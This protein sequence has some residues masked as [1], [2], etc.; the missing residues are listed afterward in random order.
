MLE[1]RI[2][3]H[4]LVVKFTRRD[5]GG[6]RATCDEVPGFYLSSIDK[7]AV[8][9]DVVPALELLFKVN[10]GI[11]VEASPL[12]HAVYQLKERPEGV[13]EEVPDAD[14]YTREYVLEAA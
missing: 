5:D 8:M 7:R 13:V 12:G 4:K 11:A 14:E 9:G 3:K 1:H 2:F 6:L 10:Q